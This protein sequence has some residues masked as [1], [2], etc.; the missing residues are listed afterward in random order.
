MIA[1]GVTL[2]SEWEKAFENTFN[3]R[4]R[5]KNTEELKIIIGQ[6]PYKQQLNGKKFSVESNIKPY[7]TLGNIVAFFVTDW[8]KIQDSLEMICNLLFNGTINSI[9]V[10]SYLRENKIPANKFADYL[11]KNYSIV[12][13]NISNNEKN[14]EDLVDISKKRTYLLLIGD[15]AKKRLKNIKSSYIKDYVEFIH[16]SGSNLNKSNTQKRYF[17]NWYNLKESSGKK[18]NIVDKFILFK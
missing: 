5:P 6:E 4:L 15:E 11:Y 12:L 3:L 14:I 13:T 18:Q 17:E 9:K 7:D 2:C 1:G 16:P 8:I 10:L